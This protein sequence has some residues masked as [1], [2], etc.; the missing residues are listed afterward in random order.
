MLE[1][2]ER[3][4]QASEPV[5]ARRPRAWARLQSQ[6]QRRHAYPV[7][8]RADIVGLLEEACRRIGRPDLLLMLP[9]LE[10]ATKAFAQRRLN[11]GDFVSVQRNIEC[12]RH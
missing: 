5:R 8:E 9:F 4:R 6:I 2:A 3:R 12:I 7:H 11:K 1:E 10:E